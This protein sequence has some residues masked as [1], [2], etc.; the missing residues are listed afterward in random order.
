MPLDRRAEL[1]VEA[2]SVFSSTPVHEMTIEEAR[3]RKQPS[4]GKLAPIVAQDD[5][6]I[7]TRTGSVS[8]RV[9]QP[10]NEIHNGHPVIVYIHGGG[11]VMGEL[12]HYDQ[13]CREL[14]SQTDMT[15]I[16]LDYRLAPEH[17]FPKGLEDCLDAVEH[18]ATEGIP[19]QA[20]S[21]QPCEHIYLCGDSAGGNLAAVV[22]NEFHDHSRIHIE[23]QI[24]IYPITDCDFDRVSYR[25]NAEGYLLTADMMKW[26]W[27]LY[28]PDLSKRPLPWTSPLQRDS[29]ANLPP[30]FVLTCEFDPL[31]DEGAAYAEC[32]QAAGV[33]TVHHEIPG[34][35]HGFMRYLQTFPQAHEAVAKIADW[36]DHTSAVSSGKSHT[37]HH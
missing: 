32:L 9:Y 30:A 36:I 29:F 22:A 15:V 20:Y 35:I 26:F 14:A 7:P 21:H 16:S 17:Q 5:C 37:S 25:D 34:M 27:E 3:A 33:E 19:G 4:V 13:L 8:A 28:C 24:L 18:L 1:F 31:R 12:D 2:V 23:G 6:R 10:R 11:W